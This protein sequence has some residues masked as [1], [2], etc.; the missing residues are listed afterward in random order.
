MEW[1]QTD[2]WDQIFICGDSDDGEFVSLDDKQVE[3]YTQIFSDVPTFTGEGPE[4]E[5]RM[6][7]IGFDF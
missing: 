5:P 2:A 1:N 3:Q 7:F 6:T 4:L